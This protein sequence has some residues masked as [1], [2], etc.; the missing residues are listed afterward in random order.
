MIVGALLEQILGGGN[1][2][3]GGGF[4]SESK[5]AVFG[6]CF[7]LL[8]STAFFFFFYTA[9]LGLMF[10]VTYMGYGLTGATV[11]LILVLGASG[12]ISPF[13]GVMFGLQGGRYS[14]TQHFG[15]SVIYLAA[16]LAAIGG[17][18]VFI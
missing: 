8:M 11:P 17:I 5:E 12:V 13:I 7:G 10:G 3:G 16:I 1:K 2:G 6:G 4:F 15:C 14:A 18:A 9:L